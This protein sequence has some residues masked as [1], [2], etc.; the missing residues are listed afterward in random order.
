MNKTP[1]ITL[2]PASADDREFL[3]DV[4]ASSREIELSMVPWDDEQ[5]RAFV[6]YQFDAQTAYYT[7]TFPDA[8]H[9]IIEA[10][11]EPVGRLYVDRRTNEIAILDVAVLPG[12]RRRGIGTY[13]IRDLQTEAAERMVSVYVEGFNPSLQLFEKL[14]FTAAENDGV[15]LRMEWRSAPGSSPASSR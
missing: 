15:N 6:V 1:K 4:Y 9:D 13:L 7:D 11:G 14:G 12:F 5:K 2:R 8:A 10:D 3:L